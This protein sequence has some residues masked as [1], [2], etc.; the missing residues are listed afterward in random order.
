MDCSDRFWTRGITLY[1]LTQAADA[2]VDRTAERL[3]L[4]IADQVENLIP[5]QHLMRIGREYMQQVG[6][7]RRQGHLPAG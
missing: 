7:K 6:F 5:A 3:G 4:R 2:S 1:F